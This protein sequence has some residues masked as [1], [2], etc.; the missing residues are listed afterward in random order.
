M[1]IGVLNGDDI[2]HEV[3]PE[4]VKVLRA[5]TAATGVVIEWVNMPIGRQALDTIGTTLPSGTL[6]QLE[7]LDGWILGPI[8][9]QAYPKR[10]EAINPHPILRKHFDLFANIRPVKSY[11]SLSSL[12][13]GIDL[14]IVRENNEGFQRV[15]PERGHD[16][17]GAGDYP[18]RF[19]EGGAR[20]VRTRAHAPEA[21]DC[22]AQEHRIQTRLRH[23]RRGVPQTRGRIL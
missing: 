4:A 9:H 11:P 6:D 10:P 15:P 3:V 7:K 21:P 1:K 8:G 13:Q 23:V 5:A 17:L 20:R 22:G 2:G 12:H 18:R 16:D 14:V 19:I